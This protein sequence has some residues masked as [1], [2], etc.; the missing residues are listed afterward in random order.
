MH[1]GAA[2]R[3]EH[4][5]MRNVRFRRVCAE[6]GSDNVDRGN[7]QKRRKDKRR[8]EKGAVQEKPDRAEGP[9]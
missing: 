5:A 9:A 3:D 4:P 1:R 8:C 7:S 2:C 6:L